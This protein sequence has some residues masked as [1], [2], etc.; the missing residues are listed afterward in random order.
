[1]EAFKGRALLMGKRIGVQYAEGFITQKT[2]GI[3]SF[4]AFIKNV[5]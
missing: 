4:D 5:T 1:M 2:I 3:N